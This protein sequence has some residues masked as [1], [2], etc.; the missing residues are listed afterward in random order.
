LTG[1]IPDIEL[2]LTEVLRWISAP[3]RS[4]SGGVTYGGEAKWVNLDSEG[5]HVLLLKFTS[6]VTL[7]EGG[8]S[9]MMVSRC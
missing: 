9:H 1:G 3:H 2:N 6:Q 7:D 8:L 4:T 5:G